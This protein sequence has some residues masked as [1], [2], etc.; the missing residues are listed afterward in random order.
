MRGELPRR[1]S[2]VRRSPHSCTS[3][4]PKV[5]TP[6]SVTQTGRSVSAWISASRCGHSW[7]CQWFQSSGKPCTAMAS[8]WSSTPCSFMLRT[9]LASIGEIPPRTRVSEP[10]SPRTAS[11]ARMAMRANIFHSESIS[12]SQWDLLFGSFHSFTASIT[13]TPPASPEAGSPR[14][15]R[16][17]FPRPRRIRRRGRRGPHPRAQATR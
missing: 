2:A 6:T 12:K 5:D 11:P 4:A 15:N 14:G 1:S 7:I 17:A 8:T 3:S 10:F 16:G 9:N 13:P